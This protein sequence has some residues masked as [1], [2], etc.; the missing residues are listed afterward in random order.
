MKESVHS[1]RLI[2]MFAFYNV[3]SEFV[4]T[5]DNSV[6][7]RRLAQKPIGHKPENIDE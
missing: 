3:R 7:P 5:C 2:V 4:A 1:I 6:S